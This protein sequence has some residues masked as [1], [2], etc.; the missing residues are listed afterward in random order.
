M[1]IPNFKRVTFLC[2]QQ[3]TNFP[4]IEED[5]DAL[6]NYELLSK[7]VEYLNKVITNENEQNQS[8]L[9]LYNSFNDLKDYVDNLDLQDEVNNKLDEMVTDG[10]LGTIINQ[11]IFGEIN[12]N[13]T[14]LNQFV[15]IEEF[16]EEDDSDDTN[17]FALAIAD[18]RPIY[19]LDNE[20]SVSEKLTI[21]EQ[22]R[23]YGKSMTDSIITATHNDYMFEYITPVQGS[24]YEHKTNIELSNFKANCKNFIKINENDLEDANWVKQGSLLH[25]L[26]KNLWVKGK[27]STLTDNNKDTNVLPS[28]ETLL[29]YGNGFNCNSIFDSAIVDCRIEDFGLGIYF[30]G[31]DINRIEHNRINGN[32]CHIYLQNCVS[33]GS[34]TLILH[35]DIL[36]N[37]RYGGIRVDG[38]RFDTIQ[39]NYFET[40]TASACHIYGV[41]ERQLTITQNRFDN[42]Q[43]ADINIIV[44]NPNNCDIICNNR[45]NPSNSSQLCY[46]NV[47]NDYVGNFGNTFN[48]NTAN[49]YANNGKLGLRNNP[50]TIT[51]KANDLLISP[52]N[53][54][55]ENQRVGGTRF[56][57][58]YFILD[59]TDNLYYFLDTT[60]N[61]SSLILQFL[62]LKKNYGKYPKIRF[63][64]K[65]SETTMYVLVRGDG[66]V[67]YNTNVS[68]SDSGTISSVDV[69]LTSNET[70]YDV[71]RIELPVKA[72]VKLYSVE[73]I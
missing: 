24:A 67:L 20:Y 53:M 37:L 16:K 70:L 33:Y 65:S 19:L 4:Y 31:C 63:K 23:I 56:V 48:Y 11:E 49:I 25:L 1:P 72:G 61:G 58:P 26:F 45:I 28:L 34:Q 51:N 2:M 10:T 9:E 71:I 30:K 29:S 43:Q 42:P 22:T 17:A 68:I 39:D 14:K 46:I 27:Y 59:E 47:L 12:A 8:I 35:N 66:N 62:N 18:G 15:T 40:Y 44:L 21:N 60:A 13:I 7:V 32:G 73:L 57:S 6:T 38:S 41:N 3:L 54:N 52:Y 69:D 36:H 64:Y 55:F 50:F 5:F